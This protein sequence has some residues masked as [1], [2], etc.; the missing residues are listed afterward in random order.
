MRKRRTAQV[1]TVP[2]VQTV[3]VKAFDSHLVGVTWRRHHSCQFRTSQSEGEVRQVGSEPSPS[4]L[5][6]LNTL[7]KPPPLVKAEP[8]SVQ[9][10][11]GPRGTI[12]RVLPDTR[13]FGKIVRRCSQFSVEKN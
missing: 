3:L 12:R 8:V 4:R 6:I 10:A 9:V 5:S 11:E 1:V 2:S 13:R 7:P